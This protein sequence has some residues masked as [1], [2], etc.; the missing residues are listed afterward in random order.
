M[1]SVKWAYADISLG[2]TISINTCSKSTANKCLISTVQCFSHSS[3]KHICKF[4]R[5]QLRYQS[6]SNNNT[7]KGSQISSHLRLLSPGMWQ[8][9]DLVEVY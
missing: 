3:C 6:N 5:L 8:L 1:H 7:S 2:T 4:H 9:C